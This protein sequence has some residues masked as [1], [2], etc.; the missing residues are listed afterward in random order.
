MH[1]FALG[2]AINAFMVTGMNY[3]IML[4]MYVPFIMIIHIKFNKVPCD[5]DCMIQSNSDDCADEEISHD[6]KSK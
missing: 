5:D 4:I 3:T 2:S 1:R 6:N